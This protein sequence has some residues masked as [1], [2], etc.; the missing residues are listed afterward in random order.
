MVGKPSFSAEYAVILRHEIKYAKSDDPFEFQKIESEKWIVEHVEAKKKI[1][2]WKEIGGGRSVLDIHVTKDVIRHRVEVTKEFSSKMFDAWKSVLSKTRYPDADYRGLDGETFQFYCHHNMFGEIW[3]PNAGLPSM[4]TDLGHK[5]AEIAK[6]EGQDRQKVVAECDEL[7]KNIQTE[8]HKTER[9]GADHPPIAPESK[10]EGKDK[11]QPEK[12]SIPVG[13]QEPAEATPIAADY[14]FKPIEIKSAPGG[15]G[16]EGRF[17][18][19]NKSKKPVMISGFDEPLDGKFLPRFER[20]QILKDGK[21]TELEVGYCGTGAEDFAMTSDKEYQFFPGLWRFDVQDTPLTCKVGLGEFWSEPFVLDWKKDRAEGKF[22]KATAEN[23][24]KLRVQFGKAGFKKELL[25]GDDFCKRLLG[26]MMKET[27]AKDIAASFQPFVGKLDVTPGI[28]LDGTIRIDFTS[29]ETRD[30]NT[31]YRGWFSIDPRKLSPE[32][33]RKA[34]KKHVEVSKWGE[35]IQM[36]MDDGNHFR[37]PLRLCINY[38]PFDKSKRPS[39]EDAEKL[40][41]RMLGVLDGWLE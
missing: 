20:Y 37:A 2:R 39:Q 35:G 7:A 24:A 25:A 15:E 13:V 9:G 36:E 33:F 34:T 40:F 4:L 3:T 28:Q 12:E 22:E 17:L 1:W 27:S 41:K 18:F 21:W 38:V 5:L 29:D 19:I 26:A 31:E 30:Y 10:S 8:S 23:L 32:W 14:V 6:V 11:H 16:Y